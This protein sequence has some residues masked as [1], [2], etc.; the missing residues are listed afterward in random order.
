MTAI[1]PMVYPFRWQGRTLAEK[2]YLPWRRT[3]AYWREKTPGE[4]MPTPLA[5]RAAEARQASEW[6]GALQPSQRAIRL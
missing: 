2:V 5:L 3:P 1:V 4:V 6:E